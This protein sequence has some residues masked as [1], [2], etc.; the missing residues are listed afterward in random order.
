MGYRSEENQD[1]IQ[2]VHAEHERKQ[3]ELAALKADEE[4]EDQKKISKYSDIN[5]LK[6]KWKIYDTQKLKVL[7][8]TFQPIFLTL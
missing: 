6:Q 3:A 4:R 1:K 5:H 7:F 2:A 8:F